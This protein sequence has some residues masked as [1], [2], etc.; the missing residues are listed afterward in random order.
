MNF[1]CSLSLIDEHFFR[2]IARTDSPD[3]YLYIAY[4]TFLLKSEMPSMRFSRVIVKSAKVA[5]I[6]DSYDEIVYFIGAFMG[7]KLLYDLPIE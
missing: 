7:F 2:S 5:V 3:S 4:Y 6:L 1:Y